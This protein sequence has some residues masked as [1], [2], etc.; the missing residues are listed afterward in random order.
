MV[1]VFAVA[2]V[3]RFC[4]HRHMVVLSKIQPTASPAHDAGLS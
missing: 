3:L 4:S 1:V 2:E